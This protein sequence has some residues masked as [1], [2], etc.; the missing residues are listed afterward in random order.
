[1]RPVRTGV[2]LSDEVD[3]LAVKPEHRAFP[4]V[5]QS[6]RARRDRVEDGLDVRRRAANDAQDV[7]GRAL[8][9]EHLLRLAQQPGVLDGNCGLVSERLE[10]RD[11]LAGEGTDPQT[12]D[13]NDT[14]GRPLGNEGRRED[15]SDPDSPLVH[16]EVRV[17]GPDY[18]LEVAH[19]DDAP[20]EHGP[21]RDS[22]VTQ[23]EWLS[24]PLRGAE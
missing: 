1:M 13:Q 17:L 14:D 22:A 2:G 23:P 20:L 7:S 8:L 19:V 11:L 24:G 3:E 6:L 21:P 5:A 10:E 18:R 9:L 16:N 12:A 15:R 4:R